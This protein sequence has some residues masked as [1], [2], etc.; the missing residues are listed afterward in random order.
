MDITAEE[1][2]TD[3]RA[4]V[5]AGVTV[6]LWASAFVSIRSAA[7]HFGPGA[8]A[9]GRLLTASVALGLVL[10]V[11]RVPPPPKQAWP[12]ILGSGVLWF[13]LYMVTLNWGEQLVDAGTAAMVVNIGP[14]VIA[15]LSGW[16][17]KEGFPSMLLAG[18]AVS[19]AG[20][21]VVGLSTS[22]G[23]SASLG[24]VLLCLVAAL[25]YGAGVV[26]QKPALQYASPLQVTTYGCFIGTAVTLPFA[27]QLVDQL[28]RAPMSA[29]L[30][31]LY[32]GLFPTALAFTTWSFA[33]SRTT[34]GKMGATTYAVPAVVVLIAWIALDEIPAGLTLLGGAI[35]LAGV[36]VSRMRRR[37]VR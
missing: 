34:A 3:R 25:T 16:L 6:L 12:G 22:H 35:C 21:V 20:A 32:L 30:N 36:A 10:L 4:L 13:G 26:L 37:G 7:A 17:L 31:M 8:L 33:L 27:W 19:F 23:G 28:P 24:G 14:I 5:A 9:F 1:N 11:K 18:M 2:R 15:L 29:V